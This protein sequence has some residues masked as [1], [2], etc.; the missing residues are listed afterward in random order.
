NV[1]T[2][3]CASHARFGAHPTSRTPDWFNK[4]ATGVSMPVERSSTGRGE[5]VHEPLLRALDRA[6]PAG[7]ELAPFFVAEV[8]RLTDRGWFFNWNGRAV[9]QH[10]DASRELALQCEMR[11][12]PRLGLAI[13]NGYAHVIAEMVLRVARHVS[14]MPSALFTLIRRCHVPSGWVPLAAAS[15]SVAVP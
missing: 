7:D 4:S 14:S 8:Q 3:S 1:A 12:Q 6:E 9:G 15:Q 11:G 2:H 13:S 5:I 10:A